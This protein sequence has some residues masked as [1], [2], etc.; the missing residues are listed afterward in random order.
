MPCLRTLRAKN[1]KPPISQ[2]FEIKVGITDKLSNM[3]FIADF[4]KMVRFIQANGFM[5]RII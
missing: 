2:R 4:E 5:N 3:K 1:K